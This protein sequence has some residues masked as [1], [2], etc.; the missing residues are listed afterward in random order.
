MTKD[1]GYTFVS[2][3]RALID[4]YVG[5]GRMADLADAAASRWQLGS[6]A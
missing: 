4:S 1:G 2:P 5:P 3:G 6:A